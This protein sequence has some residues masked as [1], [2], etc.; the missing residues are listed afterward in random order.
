MTTIFPTTITY[1]DGKRYSMLSHKGYASMPSYELVGRKVLLAE[2]DNGAIKFRREV[3][4]ISFNG[5]LYTGI[6]FKRLMNNPNYEHKRSEY[7]EDKVKLYLEDKPVKKA[8]T[9]SNG[10]IGNLPSTPVNEDPTNPNGTIGGRSSRKY[11]KSRRPNKKRGTRRRR[12][13]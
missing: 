7:L 6:N 1:K 5:K 10:T 3:P 13:H 9:S 12:Y 2:I 11:R 4:Q 8:P